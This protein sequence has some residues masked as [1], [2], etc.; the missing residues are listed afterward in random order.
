MTKF[1]TYLESN[2][3]D[4]LKRFFEEHGELQHYRKGNFFARQGEYSSQAA[5]IKD[6]TFAYTH[7]DNEGKEHY[8][9]FVFPDEFVADYTSFMRH[10]ASQVN[11]VALKPST[12]FSVNRQAL[13]DFYNT[14]M[15]TLRYNCLMAENLY[16][17]VYSRLLESYCK[18]PEERYRRLTTRYPKIEQ[19]IPLCKIASF[20][21]VTPET[22]SHIRKKIVKDS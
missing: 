2:D 17:M 7:I 4:R 3:F 18:T 8:V 21:N 19:E 10:S 16:E 12:I 15:E 13:H 9:G 22:I 20:L 5:L 6:G 11:I 1:N 14:D